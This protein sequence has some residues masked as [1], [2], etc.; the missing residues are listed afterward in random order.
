MIHTWHQRS[1][2][3]TVRSQPAQRRRRI[4]AALFIVTVALFGSK[5]TPTS[6][7]GAATA[8]P[9]VGGCA[10][11][12]ADNAWNQ[13]ITSLPVHPDSSS[14][15]ASVD[16][17]SAPLHPDFGSDPSIGLPFA[18]VPAGQAGVKVRFDESPEESDGGKYPIPARVPIEAGSDHHVLIVQRT[19]C[20]LFE[21]FNAR[22]SGSGWVAGSGAIFNLKSNALRPKGWTSA[23]AAGLP[24]L[25]GLVRY[26]EVQ[27][28]AIRHAIRVTFPKTQKGFIAPARHHAGSDDPSLPP[29]GARLRLRSDVDLSGY[30]GQARVILIA[31]Q[32]YGLIVADNGSTWFVTGATDPRW[33]DDDLQQLKRIDTSKFDFVNSGAIER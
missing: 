33:N 14:W 19:T 9:T 2:S 20:R 15:L 18:V 5:L 12:P 30:T 31:M 1:K 17:G 28:G 24:I 11:F 13:P 23:D 32:T 25:P 8:G 27:A 16:A 26:D 4:G 29:M 7:A 3:S 21:L 22:R 10:V 6:S